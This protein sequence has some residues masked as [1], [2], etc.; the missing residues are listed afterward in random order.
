LMSLG[1]PMARFTFLHSKQRTESAWTP[2]RR[3]AERP[4]PHDK[5][6]QC[7]GGPEKGAFILL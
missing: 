1:N 4:G 3:R 2:D 5:Q 7:Q 6:P